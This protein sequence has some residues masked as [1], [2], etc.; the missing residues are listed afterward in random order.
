MRTV[1]ALVAALCVGVVSGA[2]TV[3]VHTSWWSMALGLAA[4]LTTVLWLRGAAQVGFALGWAVVVGRASAPRPEGDYLVS[5]DPPGWTF[6]ACSLVLV[7]GALVAAAR[8]PGRARD[9]RL[10]GAPS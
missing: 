5:A 1:A 9:L 3:L 6:L 10:R 4:A 8:G 2:A 7:V